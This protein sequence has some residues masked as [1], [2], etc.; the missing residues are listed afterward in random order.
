MSENAPTDWPRIGVV[1]PVF[2][3]SK[4][5]AEAINS[6][7]S[8]DYPGEIHAVVVVDGDRHAETLQTASSFVGANNRSVS[9]IF[10]PNGRLP[11]ARNT[12]I[13]YLL[14]RLDDLLRHSVPGRRQPADQPVHPS[15]CA[16]LAG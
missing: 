7:L 13:R 2:G 11:A 10:R 1:I 6:V 5:V 12:G 4:L 15:L 3:H 16:G 9:A 8:Q 14:A